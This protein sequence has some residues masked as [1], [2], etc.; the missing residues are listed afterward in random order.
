MTFI[1]R[2]PWVDHTFNLGLD[3]G[4]MY[5]VLSRI[6]D[7]D[8][9]LSHHTKGLNDK[10]LSSKPDNKWSIK[11][12]VGHLIDLEEL[13]MNRFLQ[14]EK[15]VPEL[16]HADMSNQKTNQAAHNEKPIQTLLDQ[17]IAERKKLIQTFDALSIKAQ[18]H[19]AFHPRIKMRMKPVDLLFFVAEHD[20]HHITSI[21][22]LKEQSTV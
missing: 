2:Q 1:K 13:W 19:E 15:L 5:N 18:N 10:L 6:K 9:R 7:C 16:V 21:L 12:H 17:F 14:F 22:R 8:I 11:E 20:D 3:T 4:W